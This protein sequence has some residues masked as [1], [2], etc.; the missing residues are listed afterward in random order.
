VR[1]LSPLLPCIASALVLAGCS[2]GDGAGT[3]SGPGPHPSTPPSIVAW[4]TIPRVL[5]RGGTEPVRLRVFVTG[6]ASAVT[7]GIRGFAARGLSLTETTETVALPG[8]GPARV[9]EVT[10]TGAEL[11]SGFDA[12]G[13]ANFIG[14]VGARGNDGR[15]T[16]SHA[17]TTVV[18]GEW[19][20]AATARPVSTS[21]QATDHV[22]NVQVGL[23]GTAIAQFIPTQLAVIGSAAVGA[24]T[25]PDFLAIV[26]PVYQAAQ[27]SAF[28]LALRN[29][30]KGIGVQPLDRIAAPP[31]ADLQ[32]LTRLQGLIVIR[33]PA[34]VDL[35]AP[36]AVHEIG[37]RFTAYLDAVYGSPGAS[38]HWPISE[39]AI[40][41][42]GYQRGQES[43]RFAYRFERQADGSHIMRPAPIEKR[44]NTM[45]LYAM[46][47]LPASAVDSFLVF[48][49]PQSLPAPGGGVRITAPWRYI[50]ADSVIRVAGERE[51]RA[52]LAPTRFHTALVVL[53]RGRL[54]TPRELAFYDHAAAR[55]E[56]TEPLVPIDVAA[57]DAGLELPFAA[58]TLGLGRLTTR[59]TGQS[60]E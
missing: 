22:L 50:T 58:A 1:F 48:A 44:F 32:P 40:G 36:N 14:R 19:P 20:E 2:G 34:K 8:G 9:W 37:H 21:A 60:R 13:G 53:T 54:L 16:E 57:R 55:G 7:F 43:E 5:V 12:P 30:T 10:S 23:D 15:E 3:P 35:A 27:G 51:P 45:E 41:V 59:L 33:D 31:F 52:G 18:Q 26:P 47:L 42:M 11:L 6:D 28:Y 39:L 29:D 25:N 38:G 17:V 49:N 56:S 46:G 24:G 4:E